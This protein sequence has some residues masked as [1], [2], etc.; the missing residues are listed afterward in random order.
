MAILVKVKINCSSMGNIIFLCHE[1][2]EAIEMKLRKHLS[3]YKYFDFY[4]NLTPIP[5]EDIL[6][7]FQYLF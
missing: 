6:N 2:D 1:E 5:G 4:S 7:M 3:A